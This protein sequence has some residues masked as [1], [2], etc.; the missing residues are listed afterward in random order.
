MEPEN[1]TITA[2]KKSNKGLLL[3]LLILALLLAAGLGLWYF[4]TNQ[5]KPEEAKVTTTKV[6]TESA[7]TATSS[8]QPSTDDTT[9]ITAALVTKTSIAADQI[10]VSVTKVDGNYARGTVGTKGEETGGGYFLG[11]KNG[12][13]WTIVYSGQATPD[14][15]MV[16][17]ISFPIAM[18][19]E[20]LDP[21]G[22]LIKRS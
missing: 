13:T 15:T 18:A 4:M 20:C 17:P 22:N 19:P 8:A 10:S 21:N 9:A 11:Y 3:G 1:S 12:N 2:P 7:Q 16:N 5:Q 6:A 14:C